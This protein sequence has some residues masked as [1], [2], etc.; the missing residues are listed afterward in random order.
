[1]IEVR[2]E[3]KEKMSDMEMLTMIAARAIILGVASCNPHFTPFG[4]G[5]GAFFLSE[6]EEGPNMTTFK[7]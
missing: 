7:I 3:G 1:V 6:S 5:P 2:I 4:V